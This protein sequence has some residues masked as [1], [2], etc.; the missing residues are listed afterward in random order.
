MALLITQKCLSDPN[1][2]FDLGRLYL[3]KIVQEALQ[4]S[5]TGKVIKNLVFLQTSLHLPKEIG[6]SKSARLVN[7]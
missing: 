1:L 4:R 3:Y 7:V 5:L 6:L 2:T